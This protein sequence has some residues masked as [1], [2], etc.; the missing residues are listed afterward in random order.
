MQIEYCEFADDVLYDL[1][2][3][4]WVKVEDE[5]LV[6]LGITSVH[7]ALAGKLNQVKLKSRGAVLKKGQSIA[8][9]ESVRYFG[10]VRTPISGTLI[11]TNTDLE[12]RP[13]LA[14]DSPYQDGWFGKIEPSKLSEELRLLNDLKTVEEK[15]RSQVRE[16]RIRCFKA[17]P[18]HEM[19]EIGVECAAVLVRL[20]ELMGRISPNEVVHIVTDD[21]TADVEMARW[22]DQTGQVVLESRTEGKLTHVIVRKVK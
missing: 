20:N 5:S 4:V 17:Y 22:S 18:D 21:P 15:I 12:T 19:W 11:E 1:E 16:L 2:N 3:N 7:G 14:N 13:K 8:T 6:K 9:I 10:A